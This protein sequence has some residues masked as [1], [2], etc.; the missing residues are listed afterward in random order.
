MLSRLV[1]MSNAAANFKA[2]D[3]LQILDTSRRNNAAAA[4]SGVLIFHE[5]RFFQVLE[6][7]RHALVTCFNRIARDK[8]HANTVVL[9]SGD[10]QARAFGNWR[11]AYARVEELPPECR[12]AVFSLYDM[13]PRNS[14]DRGNDE[15]VRLRVRDFLASCHNLMATA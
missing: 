3:V 13:V 1:Y 9:E 4:L 14:E 12:H 6:G 2:D 10:A 8:R 5:R 15:A 11:M 7:D